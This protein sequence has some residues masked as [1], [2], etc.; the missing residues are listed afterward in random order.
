MSGKSSATTSVAQSADF[1][2]TLPAAT[3]V[4]KERRQE[5]DFSGKLLQGV[6]RETNTCSN[7]SSKSSSDNDDNEYMLLLLLLLLLFLHSLRTMTPHSLLHTSTSP[8]NFLPLL[9]LSNVII[10]Y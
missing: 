9:P 3:A 1:L 7:N 4:V 2:A 5:A 8:C 10:L 6:G